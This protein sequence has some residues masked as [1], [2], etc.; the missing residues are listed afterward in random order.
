[1]PEEKSRLIGILNALP[2]VVG[3]CMRICKEKNGNIAFNISAFPNST[4]YSFE[5]GV[6]SENDFHRVSTDSNTGNEIEQGKTLMDYA[7]EELTALGKERSEVADV[8]I[9]GKLYKE[10]NKQERHTIDLN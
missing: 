8:F 7:E 4:T 3:G 6:R 2:E 5:I 9:N 10:A 1:M